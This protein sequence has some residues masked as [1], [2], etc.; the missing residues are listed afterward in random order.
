MLPSLVTWPMSRM[1]TPLVFAFS[2]SFM[3]HSRT[4]A[5]SPGDAF[6]SSDA[7]V[8][9]ESMTASFGCRSSIASKMALRF[10]SVRM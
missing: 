3:A 9:M 7:V 2:C 1:Q 6:S 10:V 5:T 8:W 4:C